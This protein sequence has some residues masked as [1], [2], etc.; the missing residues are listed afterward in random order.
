MSKVLRPP[1]SDDLVGF[2]PY[3]KWLGIGA[4]EQPPNHYRLLGVNL[5]ESDLVVIANAA[6]AR[7][8]H[9]KTFHS[10]RHSALSQRLLNEIALAKV[11]LFNP[12]KKSEY[13]QRLRHAANG[14]VSAATSATVTPPPPAPP[15]VRNDTSPAAWVQRPEPNRVTWLSAPTRRQT[16]EEMELLALRSD[17]HGNTGGDSWVPGLRV[18]STSK[19][20]RSGGGK[21]STACQWRAGPAGDSRWCC[22]SH[23]RSIRNSGCPSGQ[24]WTSARG[25]EVARTA[26]KKQPRRRM[27]VP[28]AAESEYGDEDLSA[29]SREEPA[30]AEPVRNS[31]RKAVGR[32]PTKTVRRSQNPQVWLILSSGLNHQ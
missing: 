5:F 30:H 22:R 8:A 3:H 16:R 21:E 27:E 32:S 15:P 26:H 20:T 18:S 31:S 2:D 23:E 1:E 6:D 7:M 10:G 24:E 4:S 12:Q 13:D 9:V 28:P 11:C 25:S 29:I 19:H 14:A 17:D